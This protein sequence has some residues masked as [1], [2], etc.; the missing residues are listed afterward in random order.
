MM[1][2][3]GERFTAAGGPARHIPVMLTEAL[4]ALI[5]DDGEIIIDGTFGAGGYTRG[6][7][8]AADCAVIAIDRDPEAIAQGRAL[9]DRFPGRL[10]LIFGRYADMDRIAEGEGVVAVDGVALDLGLSSMQLDSPE[11]GFAFSHDAPL[12]MRMGKEGPTAAEIVNSL[13][14]RDLAEIIAVLGEEKRARAIARAIAARR[15]EQPILRTGELADIVARVLGRKRDE[16]K[17]PATRTFQA[18]R[19]YLNGELDE[20]AR[21]LS[22]AER[23]LKAGG[24]LVIVTFHSL[25]DRIAKRFFASRSAPGP[26]G[27]RHL[28]EPGSEA[29]EPSFRLLNRRPL[30]PGKDEIRLNPRARSARLRAGERTEAPAHALDLAALGVPRIAFAA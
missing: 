21:G 1:A 19:L 9:E 28:P 6:I 8:E 24:R 14:E 27:S 12:D 2:G 20:L 18:L 11:R 15:A 13:P 3:R 26:R 7:L 23:L 30:S 25:E 17:H 4:Q 22:A 10:T 29:R 16:M 5:P